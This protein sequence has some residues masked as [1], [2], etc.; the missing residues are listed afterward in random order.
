M[1]VTEIDF[2]CCRACL[3][4]VGAPRTEWN[5]I[6]LHVANGENAEKLKLISGIDVSWQKIFC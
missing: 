6:N 5:F 1:K 2:R 4:P 3:S